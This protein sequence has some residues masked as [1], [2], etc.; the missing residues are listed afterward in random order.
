MRNKHVDGKE[1]IVLM[2]RAIL[3]LERG[4]KRMV[5]HRDGDGLN[6]TR[7]N[8]RI[9]TASQ[10]QQNQRLSRASRSGFRG[11]SYS[12]HHQKW[13]A[14]AR[15]NRQ[16]YFLGYFDDPAKAHE[17]LVEWRREHMPFAVEERT[18]RQAA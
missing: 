14:I 2:H 10:N 9:A 7:S 5:D 17:V 13:A 11:V 4:D 18:Y 12:N 16:K 1:T 8:L 15:V 6:N 3:G